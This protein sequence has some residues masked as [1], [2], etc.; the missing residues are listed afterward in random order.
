MNSKN[1]E[2]A[3]RVLD[4]FDQHGRTDFPWQMP[5]TPYRV[6]LS[7][8]MLQQTTVAAVIPYF[9]RFVEAL[10]DIQA[11]ARAEPD[12]VMALWSGLG[13]YAR[14]R[15]LHAAAKIVVDEHAGDMPDD[16]EGLAALP[17][18]GRSTAAAILAQAFEQPAAILDGNVKRVLARHAGVPGW[19]GKASVLAALWGVAEQRLPQ[20]R[21]A[22]YAQA[23]M[24]MGATLCL[25]RKPLCAQCPVMTD[26]I[27]FATGQIADI[28]AAKPKKERP[29][30]HQ[31]FLI[32]RDQKGRLLLEK[33]PPSGI[34]GGL[35]SLPQVLT[36]T[37]D[38]FEERQ[39]L[40][41]GPAIRHEFSH[42][43]LWL[44]PVKVAEKDWA[45]AEKADW[46]WHTVHQ[47]QALGL[48]QPIRK[49]IEIYCA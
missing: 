49:L 18:I 14:A 45:V 46:G 11:L 28:P 29:V 8:I 10:P 1:Q 15:N 40:A 13:Y 21:P 47:A 41:L 38:H 32:Q 7:E 26:C 24:D 42:F 6:W 9:Q 17:G 22:D 30:R 12:T 4:W 3:E 39:C 31:K 33:R 43:S 37:G 35:W 34:W 19:P 23:M 5:R 36:E 16:M 25:R 44:E 48:P 20:Q 2:W 27:A